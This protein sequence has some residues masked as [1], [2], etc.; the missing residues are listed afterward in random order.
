MH[1]AT[2]KTE[3]PFVIDIRLLAIDDLFDSRDPSPLVDRALDKTVEDYIVDCSPRS[4]PRSASSPAA[5]AAA[6]AAAA[7]EASTAGTR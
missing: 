3:T 1:A 6:S 2:A 4:Y 5:A 7:G